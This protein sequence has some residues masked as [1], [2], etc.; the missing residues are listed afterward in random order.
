MNELIDKLNE[1][2]Y[3]IFLNNN[4]NME[5]NHVKQFVKYK[6]LMELQAM[7]YNLSDANLLILTSLLKMYTKPNL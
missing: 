4:S 5:L 7:R 3:P 6:S 1:Y 2:K